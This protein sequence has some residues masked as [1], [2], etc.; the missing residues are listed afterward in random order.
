LDFDIFPTDS[1]RFKAC[2]DDKFSG[3]RTLP[4]R[5]LP[6]RDETSTLSGLQN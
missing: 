5:L 4:V 6:G 2:S 3:S 1:N